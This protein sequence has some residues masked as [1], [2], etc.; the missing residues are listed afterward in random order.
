MRNRGLFGDKWR[1]NE[2]GR[3]FLFYHV[4]APL[5]LP[6]T[7]LVFLR[8]LIWNFWTSLFFH[9]FYFFFSFFS[10]IL[11]TLSHFSWPHVLVFLPTSIK[12]SAFYQKKKKNPKEL[13]SKILELWLKI[14]KWI[15]KSSP[16]FF[17]S[18][19]LFP[20]F[21]LLTLTSRKIH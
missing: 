2:H 20:I 13:G 14:Q 9:L 1:S 17:L 16:F 10:P 11:P 18:I 3:G 19:T 8:M 5:D 6:T 15:L 4:L 12:I 21:Y 7:S